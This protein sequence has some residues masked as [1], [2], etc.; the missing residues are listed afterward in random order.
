ML[1]CKKALQISGPDI[2][3]AAQYLV[4]KGLVS[5]A[6]KSSRITAEGLIYSYIHAGSRIGVLI[7]LNCETDFVARRQEFQ[8]LARDISMQIAACQSV[9]YISIDDVP[10][11]VILNEKNIEASKDD[12]IN[13][14]S[15]IKDK[16][17][18]GRIEKRLKEITLMDQLFIKDSNI[19]IQELIKQHIALLG[20]NIKIRRFTRFI[21]G[22]GIDKKEYN[23]KN[24]IQSIIG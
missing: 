14:P 2:N 10:E 22:E 21:L 18:A 11:S 16:I 19:S 17:I 8:Y 6:K 5:A 20:E 24:E 9:Q 15:E 3:A 4:K 1:D 7:E 13:K 23:F 12:L